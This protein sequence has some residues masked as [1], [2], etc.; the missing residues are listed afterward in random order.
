MNSVSVKSA[1]RLRTESI[2]KIEQK[3]LYCNI[4]LIKLC[5]NNYKY[6]KFVF[7]VRGLPQNFSPHMV[8]FRENTYSN[9]ASM[10]DME[11]SKRR[12]T[13]LPFEPSKSS[14]D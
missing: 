11:H 3:L 2:K 8:S 5:G 7:S 9:I 6:I 12:G 10:L 1:T 13:K 4:V 14:S